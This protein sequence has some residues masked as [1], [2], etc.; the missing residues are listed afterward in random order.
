MLGTALY[1]T[2]GVV[3]FSIF[4]LSVCCVSF[5]YIIT[6]SSI[7]IPVIPVDLWY[8]L[9]GPSMHE[10]ARWPGR[11]LDAMHTFNTENTISKMSQSTQKRLSRCRSQTRLCIHTHRSSSCLRRNQIATWC[12]W[13]AYWICIVHSLFEVTPMSWADRPTRLSEGIWWIA[14][15]EFPSPIRPE[16]WNPFH[17]FPWSG[18]LIPH[19]VATH[20]LTSHRSV[21]LSDHGEV[22]ERRQQQRRAQE[23]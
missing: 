8:S 16:K 22:T 12:T 9:L 11:T 21:W 18:F 19:S 15:L 7:T 5:C 6:S 10:S 4:C 14:F 13:Y 3:V 20:M 2:T 23:I 1:W 17:D